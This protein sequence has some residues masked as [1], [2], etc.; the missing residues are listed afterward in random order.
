MLL[1]GRQKI[2]TDEKEI[3][4]KNI[5]PVLKKAYSKHCQNAREI[6][7]LLDYEKGVQPLQREKKIRSDIDLRITDNA[8]NYVKEFKVGYFWGNPAMLVQRGNKESHNTNSNIDDVGITS[9]NEMLKN[10]E[11]IGLQDQQLAEFVEIGGIGHRM[12]DAKTD[13]EEDE[14]FWNDDGKFVGSLAKIYTLD[15]RYAFCVYHNGVDKKK[16][17]GV[18]YTRSSSGKLYFTCFTDNERF[19]IT[20]W[21]IV[22]EVQVNPLTK[23][24]IVEYERSV[25]RT[26]CFERQISDMDGLNVLVSDFANDVSQRTQ[27]M[28]WGDNIDFKEDEKGNP[29]KPKSGDWILTYSGEGKTA[30]ISPLSSGFDGTSTISA[31]SYRWNRILQKCKVPTQADSEGGGSTGT[32]MDISSGWSGAE[33]DAMREQQL[34]EAGK[35]E[36]LNLILKA[37]KLVPTTILDANSPMR[38]IHSTDIDFHFDRRRNYDMT[39]KANFIATLISKGFNGRHVIKASEAFSDPEQVWADSKEG[40]EAYQ[41]SIYDSGNESEDNNGSASD[42]ANQISNSPYLDGMNTNNEKQAV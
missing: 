35:R 1:L 27:E 34:I 42:T 31:I 30:K 29:V 25:D 28:W 6:Q 4:S 37:I 32:A 14:L 5:I 20:G 36:E 23:I 10:G 3:T 18:T 12:V 17:I 11:N 19:E 41:K 26:G 9:L 16:L 24:P 8:A 22:G 15:S 33:V 21:E 38:K 7:F 13:F 39:V 40:I 2:Y